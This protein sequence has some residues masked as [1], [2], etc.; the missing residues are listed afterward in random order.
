MRILSTTLL[1][2]VLLLSIPALA[3]TGHEHGPGGAHTHGP[4]SSNSAMKKA[5][6]QV[7]SLVERGKLGKN[8]A[9]LKASEASQK[10]FGKGNEWV[11][12]FKNHNEAD[13]AKQTLYVFYTLNGTYLATN[14]S[15][16]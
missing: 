9:G 11:V 8:W 1:T 13:P 14:F 16:K 5:E 15:G 4:I 12:T 3:G 10:N 7:K 6:A 2:S